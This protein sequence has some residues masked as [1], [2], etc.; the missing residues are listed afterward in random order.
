MS[1]VR[2]PFTLL[3]SSY[4]LRLWKDAPL[5]QGVTE[6][7]I[8]SYPNLTFEHF[9]RLQELSMANRWNLSFDEHGVGPQSVHFLQM[10]AIRPADAIND[11]RRGARH[12]D[13]QGHI[14]DITFLRQE[15]LG[16]EICDFLRPHCLKTQIDVVEQLDPSHVTQRSQC[17]R[18]ARFSAKTVAHVLEREALLFA[19]LA[20]QGIVYTFEN[21]DF[22]QA[23]SARQG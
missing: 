6:E 16:K 9:L 20:S 1:T 19:A 4:E 22:T 8:P 18:H 23:R 10:F 3:V 21:A 2:N 12:S 11:I 15:R 5:P 13:L 17:W 14:P 7:D